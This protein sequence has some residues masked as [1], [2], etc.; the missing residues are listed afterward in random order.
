MGP[1][2]F[3][4]LNYPMSTMLSKAC[5]LNALASDILLFVWEYLNINFILFFWLM[6][7][8]FLRVIL[9]ILCLS[10]T[11]PSNTCLKVVL[12]MSSL[13]GQDFLSTL[14]RCYKR[15][16]SSIPLWVFVV[17]YKWYSFTKICLFKGI[18]SLIVFCQR[19][20]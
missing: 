13:E 18:I 16:S 4:F 12:S 19:N 1:R 20:A 3:Y 6:M 2:F 10:C 9:P 8:F 5:I 15:I 7:F 11:V 17:W 14:R